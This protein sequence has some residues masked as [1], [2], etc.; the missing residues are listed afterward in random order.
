[1]EERQGDEGG[2]FNQTKTTE[3]KE[4]TVEGLLR[5]KQEV[6][7]PGE[8]LCRP[9]GG[10]VEPAPPNRVKGHLINSHINQFNMII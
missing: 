9:E 3:E 2:H 5:T 6:T 8:S 4:R 10:A 1:M 7:T